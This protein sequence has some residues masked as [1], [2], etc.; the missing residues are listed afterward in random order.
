MSPKLINAE[1]LEA[2]KGLQMDGQPNII[3]ELINT[4]FET[5]EANIQN[6]QKYYSGGQYEDV[7]REAHALKSGARTLGAEILGN[8]CQSIEDLFR[9]RND[10]TQ[11]EAELI[12]KLESI[13]T[14][15]CNELKKFLS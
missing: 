8:C 13:Y 5:S 6:I 10:I 3:V 12:P 4:F 7:S 1:I 14:Q 15:T 2:L 11:T 9:N